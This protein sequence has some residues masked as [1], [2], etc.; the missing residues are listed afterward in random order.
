MVDYYVV[1]VVVARSFITTKHKTVCSVKD[2]GPS[3]EF[4]LANNISTPGSSVR[5]M[6]AEFMTYMTYVLACTFMSN[7]VIFNHE[8]SRTNQRRFFAHVD[9]CFVAGLPPSITNT[10]YNL[11]TCMYITPGAPL[12]RLQPTIA[13]CR[14][15]SD[16]W[17]LVSQFIK[18]SL[19]AATDPF[20]ICLSTAYLVP[21]QS[22]HYE[23]KSSNFHPNQR[24][25]YH[26]NLYRGPL[27]SVASA[28]LCLVAVPFLLVPHLFGMESKC[29]LLLGG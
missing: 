29:I 25:Q 19:I 8:K 7:N 10:T 18:R 16:S 23:T 3:Y 11:H 9:V 2:F 15:C 27:S 4:E 12:Q 5:P 14:T 1:V 21:I 13:T 24:Q 20:V 26:P 28:H 17:L 22:N 6:Y